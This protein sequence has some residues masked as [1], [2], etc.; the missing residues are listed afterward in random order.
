MSKIEVHEEHTKHFRFMAIFGAIIYAAAV[1]SN[2]CFTI[3]LFGILLIL[4]LIMEMVVYIK[5]TNLL[6]RKR[7]R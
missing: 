4:S 1:I 7:R 5:L 2:N 3:M 6:E